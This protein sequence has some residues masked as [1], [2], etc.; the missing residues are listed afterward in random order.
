V[1]LS[2]IIAVY[3]EI[4]TISEVIRRV[5]AAP[6]QVPVELIFVDD[7]SVDGTREFLQSFVASA[8]E[9][10]GDIKVFLHERNQ[11]EGAAI[12]TAIAHATG[13]MILIQDADLEYDCV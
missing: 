2:V 10:T 9:V 4:A 13:T 6:V 3:N 1:K 5:R 11:G 12:R 7:C 8:E